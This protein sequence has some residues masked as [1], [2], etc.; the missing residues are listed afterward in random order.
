MIEKF[1][2]DTLQRFIDEISKRENKEKLHKQI[3]EPLVDYV[4]KKVYPYI[5]TTS[6][7]IIMILVLSFTMVYLFLKAN[8]SE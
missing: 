6:I 4:L 2:N 7:V 1:V 5:V 8:K 3:I